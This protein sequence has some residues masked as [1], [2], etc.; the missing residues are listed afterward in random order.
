MGFIS[1]KIRRGLLDPLGASRMLSET[2]GID[3]SITDPLGITKIGR[4]KDPE[5]EPIKMGESTSYENKVRKP[6]SNV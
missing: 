5:A 4:K 3:K 2:V 6:R 1:N